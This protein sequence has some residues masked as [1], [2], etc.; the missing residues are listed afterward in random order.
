MLVGKLSRCRC[1]VLLT[2]VTV[3]TRPTREA[4]AE[5]SSNQ[6]SAGVGVDTGVVVTLIGV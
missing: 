2:G 4:L 1:S 5:V 3:L 6:I